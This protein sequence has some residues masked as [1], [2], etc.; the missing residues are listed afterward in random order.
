MFQR[1]APSRPKLLLLLLLAL[2]P[3]ALA[4]RLPPAQDSET[5]QELALERDDL[6]R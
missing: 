4:H 2:G 6:D 1:P 3:A 5:E